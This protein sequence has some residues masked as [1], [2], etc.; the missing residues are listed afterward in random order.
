MTQLK[1]SI[2][3]NLPTSTIVTFANPPQ[4]SQRVLLDCGHSSGFVTWAISSHNSYCICAQLDPRDR[5]VAY[6]PA[7]EID[8]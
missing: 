4:P 2:V 6:P 7:K 1:Y 8:P 3:A 5:L